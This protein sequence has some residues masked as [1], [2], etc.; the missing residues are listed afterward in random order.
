MLYRA[1]PA[2]SVTRSLS[3]TM[4]CFGV[5]NAIIRQWRPGER[6]RLVQRQVGG[7]WQSRRVT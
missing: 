1:T 7:S 6:V 4:T 2:S 3:P 5:P